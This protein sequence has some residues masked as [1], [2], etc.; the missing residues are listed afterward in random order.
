MESHEGGEPILIGGQVVIVGFGGLLS[1]GV[2][3]DGAAGDV[4]ALVAVEIPQAEVDT[5]VG[6]DPVRHPN[7][8][9]SGPGKDAA[10]GPAGRIAAGGS[11]A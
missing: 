1:G 2:R 8:A 9:P 7:V 5:N 10:G 3:R 4:A 6:A 11:S